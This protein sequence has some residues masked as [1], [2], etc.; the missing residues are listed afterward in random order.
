M[1]RADEIARVY[2]DLA[3]LYDRRGQARLRDCNLVLAADAAYSAGREG[4]A[5]RIRLE[6]LSFNPTHLLKPYASFAEAL[7]SPDIQSYIDD[8]RLTHPPEMA[9]RELQQA[10]R[11]A[12]PAGQADLFSTSAKNPGTPPAKARSDELRGIPFKPPSPETR[13]A[14]T[15][16]PVR[17][18]P[19]VSKPVAP[20]GKPIS[21]PKSVAAVR[22]TPSETFATTA[23]K[24]ASRIPGAEPTSASRWFVDFLYVIILVG[25]LAL[26]FWTFLGP[27]VSLPW[28]P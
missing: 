10:E 3:F 15:T 2:E 20:A 16:A 5:E 1:L 27:F 24:T 4:E 17:V 11:A 23:A 8:L 6:L 7:R 22:P 25:G 18:S 12:P 21:R 19:T 28:Q 14:A 9:S 26:A 13:P